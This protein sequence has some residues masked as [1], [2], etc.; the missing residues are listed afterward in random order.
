MEAPGEADRASRAL[1]E[2]IEQA[3]LDALLAAYLQEAESGQPAEATR[4][5][6]DV[7]PRELQAATDRFVVN[8]YRATQ[9]GEEA[10]A[11]GATMGGEA[12]R[13]DAYQYLFQAAP[14]FVTP[15]DLYATES[16]VLLG[17]MEIS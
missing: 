12:A 16:L 7:D 6:E 2:P 14:D 1:G 11:M 13:S 3:E 17:S 8:F 9:P 5:L 10:R 15:A 4:D